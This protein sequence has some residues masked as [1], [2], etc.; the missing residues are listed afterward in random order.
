V[1]ASVNHRQLLEHPLVKEAVAY[2]SEALDV[3]NNAG[4]AVKSN[5]VSAFRVHVG[6]VISKG[7][8]AETRWQSVVLARKPLPC[9]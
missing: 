3:I 1:A 5:S 2:W 6:A 8:V 7:A 4:V 9:H